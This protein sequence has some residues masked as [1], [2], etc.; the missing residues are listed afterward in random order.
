[1][2]F[3]LDYDGKTWEQ[4]QDYLAECMT[5]IDAASKASGLCREH[6]YRIRS[7]KSNY[8]ISTII[9]FT[10]LGYNV[11]FDAKEKVIRINKVNE[12]E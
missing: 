11:L 9:L 6:I 4:V 10:S 5:D 1:M 8:F 12:Y 7:H 2:I 3:N